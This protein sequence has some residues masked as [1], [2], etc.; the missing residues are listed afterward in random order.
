ML[1]PHLFTSIFRCC[2]ADREI[3]SI[4][5][6][7]F[8]FTASIIIIALDMRAIYPYPYHCLR[9]ACNRIASIKLIIRWGVSRCLVAT[10]TCI[11]DMYVNG[12]VSEV[13]VFLTT[14]FTVYLVK[15]WL[16]LS[17]VITRNT[18]FLLSNGMMR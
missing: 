14:P 6:N 12:E 11:Y 8:L 9:H 2:H 15:S 18:S 5:T 1:F 4:F 17:Q 7:S 10:H 16:L 3:I 13:K